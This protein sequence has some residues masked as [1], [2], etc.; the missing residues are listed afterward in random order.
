MPTINMLVDAMQC[1]AWM[2]AW[3]LPFVYTIDNPYHKMS[4]WRAAMS[5]HE[6]HPAGEE[7]QLAS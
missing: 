1:N 5:I 4:D 7:E 2:N 6:A 3:M